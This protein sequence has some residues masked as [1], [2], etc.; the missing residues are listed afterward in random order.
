MTAQ[1]QLLVLRDLAPKHKIP[2]TTL[3]ALVAFKASEDKHDPARKQ[4]RHGPYEELTLRKTGRLPADYY[5]DDDAE[6]WG[7]RV[8]ESR[9]NILWQVLSGAMD[10]HPDFAAHYMALALDMTLGDNDYT[11][12][13]KQ[14]NKEWGEFQF[15]SHFHAGQQHSA[16]SHI[17]G[18]V[19]CPACSVLTALA[20]RDNG[21]KDLFAEM[22]TMKPQD[23]CAYLKEKN[24]LGLLDKMIPDQEEQPMIS[25]V[26]R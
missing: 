4:G 7:L 16:M 1:P 3:S 9:S 8:M 10:K 12:E 19:A 20:I 15:K 24:L 6:P 25:N 21:M 5:E 26:I 18:Q 13:L 14:L 22:Q 2:E 11:K 23:R 17:Y